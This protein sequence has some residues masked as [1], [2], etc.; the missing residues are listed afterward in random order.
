MKYIVQLLFDV[1]CDGKFSELYS[2]KVEYV[3]VYVCM[4]ITSKY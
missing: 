2:S 1:L 4:Y 3:Y